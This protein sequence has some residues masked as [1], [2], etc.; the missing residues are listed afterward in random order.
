MVSEIPTMP[1]SPVALPVLESRRVDRLRIAVHTA[2]AL[3]LLPV[4]VLVGLI[5]ALAVVVD[6]V[7]RALAS[8]ARSLGGRSPLLN[9]TPG[10]LAVRRASI[11]SRPIVTERLWKR[12]GI[13][14]R[15]SR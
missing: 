9:P 13:A 11:G 12:V 5:A 10:A 3:Y 2:L 4:I 7:G 6:R 15:S 1:G 14:R 8:L